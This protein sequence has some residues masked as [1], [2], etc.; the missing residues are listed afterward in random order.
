M[1]PFI[2][3]GDC[4]TL[5]E[6]RKLG[7]KTFEPFINESYDAEED[8][9]ERFKKIE[10]EIAKLKNKSIQEIH[11]WYYSIKDILIHNQNHLYTFEKYECFEEIFGKIKNHY[12]KEK[13]I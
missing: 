5:V 13:F 7:F 3:L 4:G 8:K 10:I 1:Q 2:V 6:L 12:K 9:I 11:N